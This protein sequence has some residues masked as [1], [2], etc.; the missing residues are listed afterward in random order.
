MSSQLQILEKNNRQDYRR[1]RFYLQNASKGIIELSEQPDG[2]QDGEIEYKRSEIYKGVSR[3]VS[4]KEL[5]F[6]KAGRDYLR[7]VYE[8]QGPGATVIFTVNYLKSDYT[9][10]EYYTGKVNLFSYDINEDGVRVSVSDTSFK[11]KVYTRDD[12]ELNLLNLTSV[13]GEA[14]TDWTVQTVLMPDTNIDR[15]AEWE[16]VIPVGFIDDSP[17]V[18]PI[19]VQ[20]GSDFTE[21]QTQLITSPINTASSGFFY[22]SETDRILT[23]HCTG[24]GAYFIGDPGDPQTFEYA[25]YAVVIDTDGSVYASHL[26]FSDSQTGEDATFV[27]TFNE[28]ITVLTGQSVILQAEM[29]PASIL[30]RF[31]YDS[32]PFRV[33]ETFDGT[34]AHTTFGF[35]YYEAFLRLCQ[36]ITSQANP[37]YSD[38]FGRT[39]TPLTTYASDGEI[40]FVLRG[41]FLRITSGLAQDGSYPLVLSFRDLFTSLANIYGLGMAVEEIGG[42]DKVR[43]ETIDHFFDTAVVLDLSDRIRAANIA[44]NCKAEW[45]YKEVSSGYQKYEYDQVEGLYEYNTKAIFSTP[46]VNDPKL[47]L[48]VKYRG[49]N[50][51]LRLLLKAPEAVDYQ[52]SKDHKGDEDIFLVDAFNDGGTYTASMAE[53]FSIVSGTIYADRSFN[54]NLTPVRNLLRNGFYLKSGLLYNI[55]DYLRWQKSDKNTKLATQLTTESALVRE[56][57]DIQVDDLTD[58]RWTNDEFT[59]EAYLTPAEKLAIDANMNGLVKLSDSKYGWILDLKTKNQDGKATFKLLRANL[60][61]ITPT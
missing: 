8:G 18:A 6:M 11:E 39:D 58:A 52:A 45:F 60:N 26:L 43:I 61:V 30:Y 36:K 40:G 29:S 16:E 17:H 19:E 42:V 47:D 25:L 13:D 51:G 4:V 53:D 22:Q 31:N 50:Q 24:G 56:N 33:D 41:I 46:L 2:W 54:L 1:Y 5:V 48:T 27:I 34:P 3:T 44:K 38:F 37:F 32:I 12:M 59:V 57:A 15:G 14:I 55:A 35:Q 10:G 9:Y 20:A 21:T 49:D 23:L 28:D 7:D